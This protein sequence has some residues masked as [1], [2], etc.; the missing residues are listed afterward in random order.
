MK[1]PLFIRAESVGWKTNSAEETAATSNR[2]L[3]NITPCFLQVEMGEV[4]V[5]IEIGVVI[6]DGRRETFIKLSFQYFSACV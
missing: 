6:Q 4:E 5:I 2:Y 3:S 1:L